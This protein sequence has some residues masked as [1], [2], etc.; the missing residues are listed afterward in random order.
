LIQWRWER[1]PVTP[2]LA[3]RWTL[4]AA[5]LVL[6]LFLLAGLLPASYSLGL[7]DTLNYTLSL[8]F[9]ISY[10]IFRLLLY[11]I[12]LPFAF[13]HALLTGQPVVLPPP[14]VPRPLPAA[15]SPTAVSGPEFVRS[16]IFWVVFLGIVG[17]SLL[18]YIRERRD[19]VAT[20][21]HI[22]FVM[23]VTRAWRW[24]RNLLRGLNDQVTEVV[25]AGLRRLRRPV[26]RGP[27]GSRPRFVNVRRL[28]PRDQVLF[29]YLALMRRGRERGLARRP[30]QTPHEYAGSLRAALPEARQDVAA[31]TQEFVGARYSGHAVSAE[32]AGRARV[33][34]ERIRRALRGQLNRAGSRDRPGN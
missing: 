31:L 27:V 1:V 18:H 34:W 20:L 2:H 10:L 15:T 32:Q 7:I 25:A 17:Y 4:Y 28:S 5:L 3:A 23:W 16:L 8:L 11:L 24:M 6:G 30:S 21:Q 22:P 33:Y 19:L 29:Y 26:G 9:A 14:I 13:L 12:S